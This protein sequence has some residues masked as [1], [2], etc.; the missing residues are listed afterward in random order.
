MKVDF[1]EVVPFGS[2]FYLHPEIS[3]EVEPST[4][5]FQKNTT[6]YLTYSEKH[7]QKLEIDPRVEYKLNNFAHRSEDFVE[8]DKGKTN[9]LFAGCSNT[10]GHSLPAKYVWTKKLYDALPVSN[11]GPFQSI[12]IPGAG[13]ERVVSNIFKYCNQFGNPDYIFIAHADFSREIVYLEETD[14]FI[15]KIHL[16]YE[17]NSLDGDKGFYLMFKF[18][19]LYRMLEIYCSSHNIKLLSYSWDS[20]TIDRAIEIFPKTFINENKALDQYAKVFDYDSIDNNDKDFLVSARDG[21][22][23]GIIHHDMVF[24]LFLSSFNKL[25][26][27]PE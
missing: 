3:Y 24:N 5:Y 25:T 11:K 9:I 1:N 21:H 22:H 23:P 16:D 6:H 27:N 17:D 18:Q 8:L 4:T 14:Q 13:I 10:F 26:T 20:V 2:K 15:N 7:D 12:G 19:L